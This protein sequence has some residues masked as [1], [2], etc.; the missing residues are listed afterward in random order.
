M[1]SIKEIAVLVKKEFNGFDSIGE[2]Y[3]GLCCA[4][5][6]VEVSIKEYESFRKVLDEELLT[7]KF[8]YTYDRLDTFRKERI[9]KDYT[10]SY[11]IWKPYSKT[12]RNKFLDKLI[13]G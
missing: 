4:L 8:G 6:S 1:K 13:K 11:F 3:S 12:Q 2:S 5:G 10:D 9:N 7:K